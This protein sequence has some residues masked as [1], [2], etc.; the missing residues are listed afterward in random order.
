[1]NYTDSILTQLDGNTQQF[2][3]KF[4]INKLNEKCKPII[5]NNNKKINEINLNEIP[6]TWKKI[7]IKLNQNIFFKNV[8]LFTA[9]LFYFMLFSIISYLNNLFFT[10]FKIPKLN[11]NHCSIPVSIDKI[12]RKFPYVQYVYRFS[13]Y[14]HV[15]NLIS[16]FVFG[17]IITKSFYL[18][19]G[20][21]LCL[22]NF[23][24]NLKNKTIEHLQCS[25]SQVAINL[26]SLMA[27][28]LTYNTTNFDNLGKIDIGNIELYT[29]LL[30]LFLYK[31]TIWNNREYHQLK[32]IKLYTSSYILQ[33]SF[34]TLEIKNFST[35]TFIQGIYVQ[36]IKNFN[37]T[38]NKG[39]KIYLQNAYD[40]LDIICNMNGNLSTN[41]KY[42]GSIILHR[43]NQTIDIKNI[44]QKSICFIPKYI[45]IKNLAKKIEEKNPDFLFIDEMLLTEEIEEI[46]L[47][48]NMALIILTDDNTKAIQII[49]DY[50]I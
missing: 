48:N 17:F 23:R 38:I 27:I 18:F 3:A 6:E 43:N 41:K 42:S 14:N 45:T 13:I 21:P 4:F 24:S 39:E 8:T 10:P 49:K 7:F 31:Y 35:Y 9:Y 5:D 26:L 2:N 22:W 44:I 50:N 11:L 32:E 40:A 36:Y 15:I 16:L 46:A 34:N 20:L 33:G 29:F 30:F 28:N 19:I 37:L 47:K 25:Y 12:V 1:M